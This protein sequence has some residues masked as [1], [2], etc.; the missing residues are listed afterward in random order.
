MRTIATGTINLD[1]SL[2]LS[3]FKID[4]QKFADNETLSKYLQDHDSHHHTPPSSSI[5]SHNN[6]K[7][8]GNKARRNK[9]MTI[10]NQSSKVSVSK[11][12]KNYSSFD[13]FSGDV[14]FGHVEKVNIELPTSPS[15]DSISSWLKQEDRIACAIWD[16]DRLT[17]L[18]AETK[19]YKLRLITLQFLTFELQPDVDVLMWSE[20]DENDDTSEVV[21]YF[22]S[23]GFEPNFI[24]GLTSS[25]RKTKNTKGQSLPMQMK[26]DVAGEMRVSF[27]GKG[28]EGTFGFTTTGKLP[29][30]LRVTPRSALY[31]A[32]S[33]I[34]NKIADFAIQSFNEGTKREFENY[35]QEEQKKS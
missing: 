28:L 10:P 26:I 29:A 18:S 19:L 15:A 23:V 12:N 13:R 3:E 21:F 5:T 22:E 6:K 16:K 9:L 2:R 25:S 14:Q 30:P 35:L 33:A 32:G 17:T 20:Y 34:S 1:G 27:D 8:I 7:I 31:A 4:S 11:T 24:Y